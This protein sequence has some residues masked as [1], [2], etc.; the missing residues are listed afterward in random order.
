MRLEGKV[1]LITGAA[2]GLGRACAMKFAKEGADLILLDVA[3]NI[4]NVPYDL[5]SQ[6]QL[7]YTADRCRELGAVVKSYKADIRD[8]AALAEVV[9]DALAK[10]GRIDVLLNNAGIAA[11]SGKILHEITEQEWLLMQDIDLN[12]AWRMMKVVGQF[13]TEQ[14]AGSII[15]VASTAGQVGYRNFSGYV[16]AKHGII[17]LTKSACLD[18]APLKVR[19]NALCPGSVRDSE[20]VEGKMLSEIARSLDVEISEHESVFTQSQPMNELVEPEDI[21]NAALWLAS[22]ESVRVT[23]SVITVDAGFVSR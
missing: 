10:F 17:G 12:G 1:A 18:Y 7:D 14:R 8:L 6:S 3:R 20:V 23:G 15:N 9:S 19:V 16:A 13:M 21:A 4:E 5:G 11:P 2:R 22:D